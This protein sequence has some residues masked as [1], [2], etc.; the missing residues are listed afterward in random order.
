M[1]QN[2]LYALLIGINDYQSTI[3]FGKEEVAFPK[4]SGCADDAMKISEYLKADTFFEPI[5]KELKNSEATKEAVVNAINEHFG[6]ATENDTV[7]MYFSGHGTQ[8]YTDKDVFDTETDGKLEC[9]ACYYD[10]N[11][12]DDFLLSDKELRWLIHNIA[13]KKP[14]IVTIFDCCH[15]G[16]NTRNAVSLTNSFPRMVEKRIAY[17]FPER[18][19]DKFIFS[20]RLGKAQ[21][22][23]EGVG[24][25]LPEGKH[26]QFSACESNESAIEMDNEGVFT[27]TLLRVLKD[28]GGDLTYHSLGSRIRQYM[29]SVFAQKPKIDPVGGNA[30]E[31][32]KI[33][34]NKPFS[35]SKKA[36]GEVTF[37]EKNGWQLNL[38][39]INGLGNNTTFLEII[40]SNNT[41]SKIKAT[42]N[43]IGVDYA[44]LTPDE[45]LDPAK[46]YTTN[47]EGLTSETLLIHF[48]MEEGLMAE[49]KNIF[50]TLLKEC[51][52]LLMPEDDE[53]K[54]QYVLR[55]RYN[56]YYFTLP[57]NKFQP[58]VK[59]VEAGLED[60]AQRLAAILKHFGS[61][62]F[63]RNLTNKDRSMLV[64]DEILKVEISVGLRSIAYQIV[65]DADEIIVNCEKINGSWKSALRVQ[66]TNLGEMDLYCTCLWLSSNFG[67][68]TDLL[69]PPVKMLEGSA[70]KKPGSSPDIVALKYKDNNVI[71]VSFDKVVKWYNWPEQTEYLKFIISTKPFDVTALQLEGLTPP[72]VPG[73]K[74]GLALS[75]GLGDDGVSANT[76][77]WFTKQ[78]KLVFPNP[79]FN[80]ITKPDLDSMLNYPDTAD[81]AL[82]LYFD[83]FTKDDTTTYKIKPAIHVIG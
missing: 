39:A 12:K 79:E 32:N 64:S 10:E 47:I 67:S 60:T 56:Q 70:Q 62:A 31:L 58:L 53:Q 26:F 66:M 82:D 14:H 16:E 68:S 44:V 54:A 75:R 69:K 72:P 55:Y 11:T 40:D 73:A 78:V 65:N 35:Q 18:S 63:I 21:F 50:D 3:K 29:R 80:T 71:P 36:F 76:E 7:F 17:V 83:V 52:T 43:F 45:Q 24:K 38:G 5:I 59:P 61:W 4:L 46:I 57:G 1:A 48:D 33:F 81:I 34:L 9:I 42:I 51:P 8:E 2:K 19:W 6:T 37:N 74:K 20:K 27:K 49:Q 13:Q 25:L 15:S 41:S 77:D 22:V 23:K 28:S 30:D